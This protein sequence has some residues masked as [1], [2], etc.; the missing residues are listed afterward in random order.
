M[1]LSCL[2]TFVET[3][4]SGNTKNEMTKAAGIDGQQ[5][6]HKSWLILGSSLTQQLKEVHII[7]D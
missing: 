4:A 5:F 7:T 6:S 2:L 1:A 3:N